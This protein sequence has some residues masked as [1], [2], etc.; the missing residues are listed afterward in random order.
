V[1]HEKLKD[2]LERAMLGLTARLRA[3]TLGDGLTSWED[4]FWIIVERP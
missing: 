2:A 3:L 4:S 1:G